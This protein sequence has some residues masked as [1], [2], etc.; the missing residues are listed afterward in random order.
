[1]SA[2]VNRV[3]GGLFL[4]TLYVALVLSPL[5]LMLVPPRPVARSFSHEL[6]VALGFVALVQIGLQFVLVARFRR[7]TEPYGI[8]AILRYHRHIGMLSLAVLLAHVVLATIARPGLAPTLLRP[9]RTG[10]P[11][12]SALVATLALVL[13][14]ALS[15]HRR[16]LHL[17]Y[18]VWR[19]THAALG[20]VLLALSLLH[21]AG[22]GA[23]VNTPAK[24]A[25]WIGFVVAVLGVYAY[26]RLVKPLQQARAPYRVVDVKPELGRTWTLTLAPVGHEG[27]R[28]LPGQFVWLKLGTSPFTPQ[29]HPFS[30]SS[31]AEHPQRLEFGIKALGD[32]TATIAAT[33]PGTLAYLDGPHGSMSVDLYPAPGYVF[34]AGGIGVTPIVSML[35]TMADRGDRRPCLLIYA[36]DSWERMPYR[37][38]LME[39]QRR[40]ELDVVHVVE[41]PP[42]DWGGEVGHV[43]AALLQ[44]RLPQERIERDYFVC[45]PNPMID[46]M[47]DLLV[48]RGVSSAAIHSERFTLV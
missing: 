4:A 21:I 40:M 11:I 33:A 37:D 32:F 22:A 16:R 41:R 15:I 12:G 5:L 23:Y 10:W 28:F 8:D 3:F 42:T 48:A 24:W 30:F 13:L 39:L 6:T 46:A 27:L 34:I 19:G 44:R 18:E 26:L 29:E 35:R 7:L 14:V 31:S 9:W 47:E 43:D 20:V 25:V 2:P 1:M 17:S 36:D 45:G 38:D